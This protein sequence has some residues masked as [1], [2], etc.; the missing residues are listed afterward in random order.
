MKSPVVILPGIGGSGPKHWQSL[1]EDQ[2][3]VSA[4][5]FLRMMPADWDHPD[6]DDWIMALD[7]ALAQIPAPPVLVA[8]SLS[9]LLVVHW[10]ARQQ[11]T[12]LRA[13]KGVFMVAPPNPASAQFPVEAA[14]FASVPQHELPFPTLLVG[15]ENDP[16]AHPEHMARCARNW[17]AGLVMAGALGHINEASNI[18]DWPQ[19]QALLTAFGTGLGD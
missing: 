4:R 13:I 15:S 17:Q 8:H 7:A 1:W 9:C 6:L 5:P 14:G 2:W 12:A 3:R 19:G 16:Y 18:G 11:N 10:A